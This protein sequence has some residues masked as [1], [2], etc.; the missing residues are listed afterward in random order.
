MEK[1]GDTKAFVCRLTQ[2]F[3]FKF[4][5]DMIICK[6]VEKVI[7]SGETKPALMVCEDGERWV[8]KGI[9]NDQG[10]KAIFNEFIAGQLATWLGLPWPESRIVRIGQQALG[11][12]QGNAYPVKSE[13]GVG[14]RYV[15]DLQDIGWPKGGFR[16]SATFNDRNRQHILSFFPVDKTWSAFYG[17]VVFDNWVFLQDKKYDTLKKTNRGKPFF[18]DGTMALSGLDWNEQELG[19]AAHRLSIASP[20]LKGIISSS[21]GFN[22]WTKRLGQFPENCDPLALSKIPAEWK[23]PLSYIK[24][25]RFLFSRTADEFAPM[26]RD[27]VE[28]MRYG[29]E[30]AS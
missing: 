2:C 17:K 13:W 14:T 27:W 18:L 8:V 28:M 21:R 11:W 10:D 7:C 1:M 9:G 12:I 5:T 26:V 23:V 6:K 16:P 22:V 19:W 29:G 20:Y 30:L 4:L 24:Q 25:V 3:K 15:A